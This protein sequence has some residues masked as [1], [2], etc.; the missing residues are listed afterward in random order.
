MG[1]ASGG[2]LNLYDSCCCLGRLCGHGRESGLGSEPRGAPVFIE[3]AEEKEKP[4][5]NKEGVAS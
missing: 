3:H 5:R 1:G 4:E 2:H